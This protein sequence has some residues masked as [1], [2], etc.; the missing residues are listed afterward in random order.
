MIYV[1]VSRK[2]IYP[3]IMAKRLANR[4]I[5][6]TGGGAGIGRACVNQCLGEGATVA[7]L[8]QDVDDLVRTVEEEGLASFISPIQVDIAHAQQVATGVKQAALKL[9]GLDGVINS[10]GIDLFTPFDKMKWDDWD[11]ILAVNLTGAM[12]VCHQALPYLRS[13]PHSSIV[14]IS[15]GAGLLP[16][17]NRVAYCA[18]KAALVMATKALA[19]DLGTSSIRV[20]AVCPGAVDT[21]LFRR[22]VSDQQ[23]VREIVARYAM[24]RLGTVS[25]IA[26]AVIF[27]LSDEA[28]LITGTAL[29]VDGGRTFH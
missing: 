12:H 8:D 4:K 18:S 14:N 13:R 15:S 10:A 26:A 7:V 3:K 20:N 29:A 22:N 1:H 24:N 23:Q 11:R 9:E 19:M 2:T 27:L 21:S 16:I 28:S 6:I 5:L 25:E 17:P